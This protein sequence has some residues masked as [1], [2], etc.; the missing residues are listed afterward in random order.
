MTSARKAIA[1]GATT[2]ALLGISALTRTMHVPRASDDALL[3]LSWHARGERVERCRRA[4]DAELAAQP[5]HMRQALICEGQRVA[6]YR[7]S[8]VIDERTATDAPVPGSGGRGDGSL[9][10]LHEH[11]VSPGTHRVRV[12]FAKVVATAP[13]SGEH[14]ARRQT[15]PPVLALDTTLLFAPRT[16]LLVTYAPELERLVVV[17]PRPTGSVP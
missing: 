17:A 14:D 6:P 1:L 15:V 10:V 16:V 2:I 8:V 5:A 4:T 11:A 12:R 3:R 7:L 13:D 9:Y